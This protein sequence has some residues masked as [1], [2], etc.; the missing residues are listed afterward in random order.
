MAAR[1]IISC[2]FV[3]T[4][5]KSLD[6]IGRMLTLMSS[7]SELVAEAMSHAGEWIE[8]VCRVAIGLAGVVVLVL[9]NTDGDETRLQI[10][11]CM[12]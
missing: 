10:K 2:P 4:K 3:R 5:K 1:A 7:S 8:T 9:P 12:L 6:G 11:L